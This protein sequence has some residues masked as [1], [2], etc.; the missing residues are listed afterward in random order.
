MKII[1]VKPC[2]KAAIVVI[3]FVCLP[4]LTAT[5]QKLDY[6]GLPQWSQQQEGITNYWLYTPDNLEEG[7]VY[8]IA[9]FLHGCCPEDEVLRPRSTVDPPLRMWHHF[10]ENTQAIPT[11]I[12]APVSKRGWTQHIDNLKKVMDDLV[13]YKQGDA[14][15]I[16]ITGFS[17]GGGGTW[18]FLNRYPDYFAAAIPMGSNLRGNI[19]NLK[20]IP[21]WANI[22]EN[23]RNAGPLKDSIVVFRAVNGDPRGA[24]EWVTGVNPR[25]TEHDGIGHG[26]QWNAVSSQ[27]LLS[28]AYDKKND[29]N[30]YPVVYFKS[31]GQLQTF[32][33]GEKVPFEL[34][35]GDSDSKIEKIEVYLNGSLVANLVQPPYSGQVGIEPGDN[36][37]MGKACD[38]QGKSSTATVLIRTDIEP[39]FLTGILPVARQGE[40]LKVPVEVRGNQDVTFRLST[41]SDPLPEDLSL[42]PSGILEGIPVVT[43]DFDFTV[44]VSDADGDQAEKEFGLIIEPKN[45]NEVIVSNVTASNGKRYHISKLK[46][47]SPPFSG[48]NSETNISDPSVYE[49]I[50]YIMTDHGDRDSTDTD[51]LS[52]DVD[53]DVIVYIAYE[54]CDHLYHS[55]IPDWLK[56]YRKE[57][58]GQIVTEYFYF[59]TYSKTFPKGR[60][61]LPGANASNNNVNNNF[62][63]LVRMQN[64]G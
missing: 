53:E 38:Q 36:V 51:Y 62:M 56:D 59:D 3:L 64:P 27:D 35:A 49:G 30:A 12:I 2:H 52:F 1:T 23:D 54:K 5:A 24:Y 28:W 13:T 4:R 63:V 21:V 11:Y 26:V 39:E 46:K 8:P 43:G 7:K 10:G 44:S 22:G 57:E 29:G 37:L 20:D 25:Y 50:T 58:C 33:A 16:Y 60:I 18:Q 19:E 61:T 40:L 42:S 45:K 34:F 6:K 15:R 17:M 48:K 55:S 41:G 32:E 9:L 47:G 31:P 14:Q